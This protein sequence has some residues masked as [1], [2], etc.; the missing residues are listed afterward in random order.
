MA[1]RKYQIVDNVAARIGSVKRI[2]LGRRF[3]IWLVALVVAIF[4][5]WQNKSWFVAAMVNGRPV[6]RWQLEDR[7]VKGYGRETLEELVS[8]Q[9]IRQAGAKK[10]I[11]VSE[12]QVSGKITDLE[13]SLAGRISLSDALAQQGM[14]M[15][16]L[17]LLARQQLLIE[18][19]VAEEVTVSEEEISDYVEK[20][21]ELLAATEAGEMRQEAKKAMM[22]KKQSDAFRKLLEDLKNQAKVIKFL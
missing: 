16:D 10:G 3:L 15:D 12:K 17:R 14:T 2:V 8:E 13:K 19:L 6:F 21:K 22:A 1:K 18:R 4:L 9:L 11:T 7:L 5:L 20:S